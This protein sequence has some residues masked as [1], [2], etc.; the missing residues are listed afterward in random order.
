MSFQNKILKLGDM[1]PLERIDRVIDFQR[2]RLISIVSWSFVLDIYGSTE[3]RRNRVY[4]KHV[5]ERT[6]LVG[7]FPQWRELPHLIQ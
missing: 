7:L 4:K 6:T 3:H 1:M 2:N 5:W